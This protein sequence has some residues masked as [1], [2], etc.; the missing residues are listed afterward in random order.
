MVIIRLVL[1]LSMATCIFMYDDI[2]FQ[3]AA[4]L[5]LIIS[6]GNVSCLVLHTRH[7]MLK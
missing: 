7:E 2:L 1:N 6:T 3:F 4:A 5:L